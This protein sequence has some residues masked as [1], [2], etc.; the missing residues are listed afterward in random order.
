MKCENFEYSMFPAYLRGSVGG[1]DFNEEPII[2]SGSSQVYSSSKLC[3]KFIEGRWSED[4]PMVMSRSSSAISSSPFQNKSKL[5]FVTGGFGSNFDVRLNTSEVLTTEGWR[6]VFP[7]LPVKI[8][9]HCMTL[10]NAHTAI[11]V[12]GYQDEQRNSA[13]TWIFDTLK[14]VWFAGALKHVQFSKFYFLSSWN[15]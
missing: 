2:C 6:Q 8:A 10:V 12:G 13:N 9:S 11:V 3:Y 1:L 5:F 15:I 14:M 7:S 4:E